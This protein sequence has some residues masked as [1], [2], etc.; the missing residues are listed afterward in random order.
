VTGKEP[1]FLRDM[2]LDNFT[3]AL[4]LLA[5]EVA[6]LRE[7][8]TALEDLLETAGI[9]ARAGVET[10]RLSSAAA[11]RSEAA[12]KGLAERLWSELSR[13]ERTAS[14]ITPAALDYWRGKR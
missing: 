6:V 13:D 7:R 10:H 8:L 1:A 4:T 9:V 12:M 5:S 11:A 14:T 3:G 2:P